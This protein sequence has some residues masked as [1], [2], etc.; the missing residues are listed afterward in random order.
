MARRLIITTGIALAVA[1]GL[2]PAPAPAQV[3]GA[4]TGRPDAPARVSG[5]P[6]ADGATGLPDLAAAPAKD[7]PGPSA[8]G[9]PPPV[10]GD[11]PAPMPAPPAPTP[12][13]PADDVRQTRADPPPAAS[14][15]A[16]AG[17]LPEG[18]E[19]EGAFVLRPEKL[20]AGPQSA[21][22]T[23][24]IQAPPTVNVDLPVWIKVVVRNKGQAE[25]ANVVVRY[26]MPEKLEFLSSQP[27]ARPSGPVIAWSLGGLPPGAERVLKVRAK[28]TEAR[29]MDHAATVTMAT[30][31]RAKMVVKQPRLKVE[32]SVSPGKVLKGQQVKFSISVSNPGTGP[33]RDVAVQAKLTAGLKHDEGSYIEQVIGAIGPGET[34]PL[35]ALMVDAVAGGEQSCTVS[36]SSPDVAKDSDDAHAT[37]A[38]TVVEPVLK[39]ALSGHDKRITNT[40]ALYQLFV[41]NPGTAPARH[42]RVTAFLPLG[43]KLFVPKDASFDS[44]SR[45]L[46]WTIPQLDPKDKAE[47]KFK[48]LMGGIG[49]YQIDAEAKGDGLLSAKSTLTTHVTGMAD[50]QFEVVER[51]RALDVGEET[52]F[53]VRVKNNGSKDATKLLISAKVAENLEI[54]GASGTEEPAKVKPNDKT[55]LLFP[56]IERLAPKGEMTLSI[57]V[58]A[59]DKPG[60]AT[61]RVSLMHDDLGNSTLSRE[62]PVTVMEPRK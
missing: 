42:V 25:A 4:R 8:V 9:A 16:P 36:V 20:G 2:R 61:C 54:V 26:L 15:T 56:P 37:R 14:P 19:A 62:T 49:R 44:A 1:C 53:E 50:V 52:D 13:A 58:R 31:S 7:E 34:V 40:P 45:R 48:V 5:E 35:D 46:T 32:Q 59:L 30:G 43:G 12:V 24:E 57:R 47:F 29:L 21:T 38:V 10:D 51:T 18:Q 11:P 3:A 22:L 23:V 41:E 39:L 17:T 55:E 6:K 33:A 27:E 28:A 60:V